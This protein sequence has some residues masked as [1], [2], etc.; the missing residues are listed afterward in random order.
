MIF[1]T[2]N[3]FADAVSVAAA[4]GTYNLGNQIDRQAAGLTLDGGVPVYLCINVD[5]AIVTGGVAGTIQFYVC[6]D[7]TASIAT[8]ATESRHLLTAQ[9]VTDDD[10]T[11]PAGQTLYFGAL[12][13]AVDYVSRAVAG[14]W[15]TTGPGAPYE[16][17]LGVNYIIGTTTTTAGKV[18]AFLTLDPR[19]WKSYADAVN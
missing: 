14:T 4:A 10:P 17:Y 2:F 3:E 7:N 1:D 8:N 19:G 16:R 13:M 18:N 11:I 12:P 6:S 9:F 5:T 15:T